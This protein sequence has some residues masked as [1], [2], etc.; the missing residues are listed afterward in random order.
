MYRTVQGDTWGIVSK[1]GYG[2]ELQ[3]RVLIAANPAVRDVVI[4]PAG[5][6]LQTPAIKKRQPIRCRLGKEAKA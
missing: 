1:K 2:R 4:F 3:M 5:I 6:E